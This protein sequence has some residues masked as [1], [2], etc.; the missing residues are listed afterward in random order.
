M[1]IVTAAA[2]LKSTKI[3][4]DFLITKKQKDQ[5]KYV[6]YVISNRSSARLKWI[7]PA[8][9]ICGLVIYW[10]CS[11]R[12]VLTRIIVTVIIIIVSMLLIL[13]LFKLV[14]ST[15]TSVKP[16]YVNTINKVPINDNV[17]HENSYI[18]GLND[19]SSSSVLTNNNDHLPQSTTEVK[20][21]NTQ[22]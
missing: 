19:I 16:P 5:T 21:V 15:N 10:M 22:S 9:L 20:L 6:R 14:S 7:L 1:V 8:I 13:C 3:D 18:S 17:V 2:Q 4:M 12:S 11:H